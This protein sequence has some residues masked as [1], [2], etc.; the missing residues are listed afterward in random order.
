MIRRTSLVV[1]LA[2]ALAACTAKAQAGKVGPLV[3]KGDG[4]A[5]SAA[6][7]QARIDEQ[8]PLIRP[9]FAQLDA[10]KMLVDNLLRV[11]LLAHAAEKEGLANDPDVRYALRTVLASKYQQ[12]FLQ[13]PERVKNAI[14]DAEVARY[15][16]E[17]PEEF[18]Q[19]LRVHLA[20]VLVAR[21]EA[22]YAVARERCDD[23]AGNVKDVC[24]TEAKANESKALAEAKMGKE[25]VRAEKDAG[26]ASLAQDEPAERRAAGAGAFLFRDGAANPLPFLDV[27]A[28]GR[29]LSLEEKPARPKGSTSFIDCILTPPNATASRSTHW[30][31]IATSSDGPKPGS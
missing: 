7:L 10:K 13:D 3:A 30:N 23:K 26:T 24:V 22:T 9:A 4:V 20:H 1:A 11:E 18:H 29:A 14:S 8:N 5:L 28:Q 12:K 27:D 15:Y 17:H 19:P 2:A 31:I 16:E 21:A 25:I 6:D